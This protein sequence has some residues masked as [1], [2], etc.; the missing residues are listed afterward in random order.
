M[1]DH[2]LLEG[3]RVEVVSLPHCFVP[4]PQTLLKS[5]DLKLVF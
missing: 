2:L 5:F 3:R 1:K 4:L